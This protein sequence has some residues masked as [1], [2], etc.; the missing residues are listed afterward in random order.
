MRLNKLLVIKSWTMAI[1]SSVLPGDLLICS[2]F[3]GSDR[4]IQNFSGLQLC[5]RVT[6]TS[7]ISLG[8]NAAR[9][10]GN[11]RC[12]F[13]NYGSNCDLDMNCDK[14]RSYI[15]EGRPLFKAFSRASS[16]VKL[17]PQMLIQHSA[18]QGGHGMVMNWNAMDY[19][20]GG[21]LGK[22]IL[23]DEIKLYGET[24]NDKALD[25][26]LCQDSFSEMKL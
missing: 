13:V 22:C 11:F 20:H 7:C 26:S 9:V 19:A 3:I 21:L 18:V 17:F 10:A 4:Y 1:A 6:M 24:E 2:T 8:S 15:V 16:L 25:E 14:C 5:L 12:G 23:V